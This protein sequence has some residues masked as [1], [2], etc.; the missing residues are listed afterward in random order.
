M[1]WGGTDEVIW[2]LFASLVHDSVFF[3]K[4]FSFLDFYLNNVASG[5]MGVM[6]THG[7]K[8]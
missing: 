8:G 3:Q 2:L 1:G 4:V 6:G 7:G 5:H